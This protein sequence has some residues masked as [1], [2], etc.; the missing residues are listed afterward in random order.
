MNARV[1]HR[2]A[3][4]EESSLAAAALSTA[5]APCCSLV[6]DSQGLGEGSGQFAMGISS[7][8][9]SLVRN[10]KEQPRPLEAIQKYDFSFERTTA[11]VSRI[12]A[13]TARTWEKSLVSQYSACGL[14]KTFAQFSWGQNGVN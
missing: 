4:D 13:G 9:A 10:R 3:A 12:T 5:A 8:A 1:G 6:D 11:F 14:H 2:L 7:N